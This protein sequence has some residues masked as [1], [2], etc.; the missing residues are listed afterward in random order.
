[1]EF[2]PRSRCGLVNS[3]GAKREGDAEFPNVFDFLLLTGK[4]SLLVLVVSGEGICS[5]RV[6][7]SLF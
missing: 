2:G 4:I 7:I 1:M 6:F 3:S 5:D